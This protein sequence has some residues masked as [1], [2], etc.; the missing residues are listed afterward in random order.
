MFGYINAHKAELKMRE[1]YRYKAFYCGLCRELQKKHGRIGQM[2]LTYDMTLFIILL[3]SLYEADT[4]KEMHRCVVHPL[5]KQE[6]LRNHITEYAA[7]MNIILAYHHF[8]DD[9]KDE[10]SFSGYGAA[11][12][13][14]RDYAGLAKKYPRQSKA[15]E[16]GLMELSNYEKANSDDIDLV[17]GIFG[18]VMAEILVMDEDIWAQS[19]RNIGYYL[20][21]YIYIMDAYEDLEEDLIKGRYNPLIHRKNLP[22]YEEDMH[23]ILTLMMTEC[24][25]EFEKLPCLRD[26][27]I[28][29]NIFYAGVWERYD[30]LRRKKG[31]T[32][33]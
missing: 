2:T 9:W 21:K 7:N 3:S 15:I 27:E 14:R 12:I 16:E 29:R 26:V 18:K 31:S 13:I 24:T 30:E 20:G 25:K 33:E 6:Q 1:Y 19:L 23:M 22:S 4:Q 5:K 28:I 8:I 17:A 11:K 10:R 32:K